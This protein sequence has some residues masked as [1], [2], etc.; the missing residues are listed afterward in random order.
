VCGADQTARSCRQLRRLPVLR[1]TGG[2]GYVRQTTST[3]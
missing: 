2:T 1:R 3:D